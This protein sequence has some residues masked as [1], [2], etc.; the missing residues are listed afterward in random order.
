MP[1]C[2][3]GQL[4]AAVAAGGGGG[5]GAGGGAGGPLG[6]CLPFPIA[7]TQQGSQ[8]GRELTFQGDQRPSSV[9]KFQEQGNIDESELILA[10]DR[11]NLDASIPR[12]HLTTG[13]AIKVA[14]DV[15]MI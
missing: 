13:V 3:H 14:L 5:N 7:Q 1:L 6:P 8:Q 9:A 12:K 2:L 15:C 4:G 10:T 11:W